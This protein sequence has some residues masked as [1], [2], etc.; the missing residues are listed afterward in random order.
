MI[1]RGGSYILDAKGFHLAEVI[2]KEVQ[3]RAHPG[4]MIGFAISRAKMRI[5]MLGF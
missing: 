4:S 1:E 5:F 2:C 3:F